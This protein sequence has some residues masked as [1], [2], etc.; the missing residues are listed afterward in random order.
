MKLPDP[1]LPWPITM[2]AVALVAEAEGCKLQAYKCPAGVWTI[3]WG[4]TDGVYPGM[5]WTQEQADFRLCE[6]LTDFTKQVKS[7]LTV[8]AEPNQLGAMV[9]LAYNIGLGGFKGSTVL[10]AHNKGDDQAASRAFGLWNKAKVNGVLTV[11]P[12]LTRRRA[13]EAALYLKQESYAVPE[14]MPQAVS[15]DG[16]LTESPIAKGG[17]VTAGAGAFSLVSAAS[18]NVEMLN[19]LT[20]GIKEFVGVIGINIS[21]SWVFPAILIV[22]GLAI[23]WWRKKQRDDGWT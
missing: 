2:D 9:S 12:G 8:H 11:L 16:T 15:G 17:A 21:M 5:V 1:S 23:I 20:E 19:G 6:S 18:E 3:G 7:M 10:K 22:T 4:E 14:V 13:A